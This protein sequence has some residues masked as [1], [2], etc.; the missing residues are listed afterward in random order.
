[1]IYLTEGNTPLNE[2]YNDEIVHLG[3]NTYQLTFRFPTSDPKW[4]LLKEETFLTADDLHGEQDFYIFEVEKQQGYIQVYANQVISLLN[5][6]IVS[7][8]EVDRVSGTRVLS[9]FA[10]SITRAN[11]FSFF[12]DIDDR[13]TLNIKDKN[14]MEV[15]AKGKHSILGQWGGDMVRNGYNLRLL[16]N[17]GSENE[18]LFM[19]KKNLS[20]YQHKTST[21]SLKTRI[22]FKTTVKGEGEN[23]V[24][25]DYMVVIDSPLLGNYSQIY[26]DVVE[27]NDQDVTD[28]ASLIEYGKQYFRTSMCDMLEDNLEISVVGQSDVAVQM[29]DVVSFYHEWYG[30]DVRKKITKYTYSPMAK[31]LKSIGFGTFQSSLANAI[32]GIVNDAVLNESRNLHQIF[33]ER[34]KKE[35]ANADRAFDAEFSKREKTIT[36]AIELAKAK[37]EEVKQEL[38]DTINQRF[39]SFDNGPLKEA[40]RKAEEALRNAGA[41]SSL[42]QES[43]RIGLDSVARLEAFKSQTTSAQTALSGDLDA[44]KRTIVNDIRPKQAQV[45]AEIAKQVEALVQTKKELSGASTLLAQEA[46]RIELDSVARLEAFKSQTTSAQTALSGDLDVLKRTIANDIRPKQAQAE[47]EIAKQVEALSRTK[48]ELSGASTLLAQEAKRIELDSVARLEAFKS[49]TTSAQTAL[50]GDLDVLKRTIANDIRPKQAQAETEIAKQV[51]ALSRTKNELAGVKSAQATY[52]ETTTRRLSELTNLA[53]GKASKSELTQ[54]AEELASRIASVQ[55]GSSR[56]YF[57][58]SRSRTFTTGGQAV[59]DYRTFIVPDFWKNSDRFKRDYVRISFDVTFPV[60]LVND[61]PAMVHF[62]AHPWYAYRNL[63][64]KGGTVERQHFEFTIDLSSSSEDYQTNN[65]FIRFG[66]N[67]GF[68][69]GLQVV[70]EN[71]MLSVGN[72]FP[73]YQPA[74]E[75]QEDRVSVVES[76]FKQRADSLDAGVSRLT[77]GLRTKADISSLNVTAE[78]IRQ[79]VKSLETDTQNKL[80]QKLSQ[81]EFE[82]R[83]GSIRQEILNATKDKASKSELT[84]TAEELASKI[85][86]V[87]LGRRNLLKGTKELARY[88]P[89]SEYNGFKVIRTVAG[90]TRYQDSY[91]ERT[92]IPTAGTEYIAI[93]YARASENDYPV[94]CHFYNPN[95]VVSSENSSGYKSRSS[96]GL[97]IIRLSTDWQ[98]CWVKWTQ[99]ATD[100]A[101]TVIIGRHGPQ[102]GGKEGVWVEICA[103][104]IFEGNLAGDWSPAYED[105]D[106]RV[107][108]VESNF[109]QRADSLEAGVSRL[110]EGLRTKADISSLNVTAENIRQSVKSLETDT[111]NKLNQKL[112]QAE[113]EVRAGSIRQEILNATKDKASKS[114]LTQTA[115]E[116]SSKIASVQ[117]G[118]RNYIRGTKRMMLA[119]GLWASGTFRPSGAGTAKTI[120]VSDSPVT[121][122]DKA[123]RLTSSN[124]RDQ[125]G[126]AQ[127]GFYISQGTYTMSCWVKGRRGQKVK[128]QTYWQVNDNSGISPIFTL[129]DENWTKLSFTSARNRAGV[130]SIGYVYL[131]NA[132]VGEYLDVLAPQLE[133]GSLATSSKEAPEDI[134]GQISTV[135]STFK[136][137]ANSLDAG[138]R[139]LTEGLRTKVD[140]SSLNV[141]A[142][143]IRQSVKRLETDT[144]NKLNQKLSQAEFEVRAGSIRQEILNATK[145][146]ASKSELTQTAEELSSKIASV[147]ASGRNL[148]LNSLFKQ[149]ISKTGIWTTSTYTAA[150]DSESKYLGHK[151]LKIIGLNPSGRDGGNP[152]VTYPALGQFGKV[153]PGS[154]TNQDVTISFYAKANKNGIMLRSRLGN[155]GYKTGNV[156]LSTEI[157]RYVVHI[158]KGWTNESKQTTNEWLFNFNQEGTVWIWMPKFEISDVDTS[159]SEAPEDI[160][161]QISTVESTFKQRANSLEAGVNRLTEGLRTKVDISALN[162]TAENIRQSVKSLETDTQNKLNQKLS[163]AEFEVRAGSIRQEILNA[164]KDKA[165]KSEL[166]QTAEE[167]SSKIASVQVGGINLLRNT[168]S[169]L[170]GDR[171]KGCWMSTS[172]GNGR[173]ISVEVLDPPKK[174]IKNMIRVI[175]NTNGGNKD[176]TQLVGLRIGEKYTI[177]CYARIASDSPNANVNL[178]F[179]SWANNTDLNRKFQKSISHKNWQKYSFTFTADAIENSIQFGQSGAGIIEICAPKIESGT[180]ATDY[181]EAPE[182]IEGQISTVESTFKQRANSLDA[183]V[184]RLTEGLRTKVDISA[185]NVTAENIRQSVKSLET[186]TQNKLNQKLSQAEF[187][188]RAG[189]IRQEILNATKDKADKT[190]VVSE[191]GKL[192]EEFS[193]MKVGGRNLWIKS[194]T[195]G[196]VIEKLPENH[197]TGQKECYRLENNSTLTFN[198]EPDFSSRLYQKVTFSA[199]IKYENVVQGR[200]FWNVFNC[201]KHYLFRKN[202]ETGVQSGPDYATLGMY[203]GSADWKYITFTYDYSEKTNFDQLKTS[204]RFNLEGATSGTAWVTGI[205]VEIGSVAT[206]WS[207]AP[208]DADGLITEAKATFERT[209]QGLR[210]DLSAIQEYVNKDGQRQEALRTYSREE[211]ARQATA[212]RELVNRDFVGKA[213]YQEDVK[214]IN[215]RIE[216]VKT[217]ANKD[218]ASQI[219]SYRQSVDGKFT[220]ISSQIT[221]YKQ[222]VGGQ[223]SGLSNRLTSSEQGTT[224]QISN[225]SNRINSN[226]QGTDNQIS[227]LKTQVATNKDNAERQMGRISDQVSANKANA[228]SQFANVTNQ[229]AR[230]VETTDFQRVKETSKLYERILGN[231]E[232]GIADKVARMALTNQLFQVEVAKN[233]SNGQNLLK[234]T[235][236]FS[237]GW[238][239]KGANW[240]KHAEKYKGVDVLFKNNSWNGVGQ[241]IDAKIGEVYT[242]SLWMKSDWKNDTVNFYVNRNGSVEKGWG[243]PSE[244]SVAITSEWKRYSFTFKITVDGFIFPRVERLNQN[245]NLY[246]AGLK[247]EK[248]SYATPY[249]EAPE[250]TDEAIRSVQSQLTGSWAVQNINSAGDIISGI[251]LGAN[252]HNRFVGKLTHITGETL[253]DRAVIKSAMVD[254]LKTGNFEAGSVTTTILDA[255]AV[256]AEKLKVDNALI[257]KLTANDAFIDQL[258]SK[259]IFSIKVESVI[260]SSTF[261][262]AYQGRIGGFTLGQFDQGGGRWISG[263]NQ[264]SVGMGNGA[265]HGVR[266]AF[267]ANWGNNWNYA[268]PKAWNVNTDGKMYCRNEVGF[269]DQVDFSNS[270]RANFYGNTTFSR[271]P[272]FSNGIELGSKDVLGDGWNPKGGR[273]AVVWWNQVGSGSVKYWMEQKSDRRLKENITDTAVKALDKINRLRMVAFDFI[274][275]KKHEEIGLIAQEAETIVPRIVS[276]DPEN[277]D[278]YLH[279]DYTALVP[280]LIKA[281]QELNQKIEK[282]EK[283]IA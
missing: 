45:E 180:L 262:E 51:E 214:G 248:G 196:A 264:F 20:S 178:L 170:I 172:G 40:K 14:A 275:N 212:V 157:K 186:D 184:S 103:P 71:A 56:N 129:K 224:T 252:G 167:L 90:A 53:N 198:L 230:K 181:S 282:M 69:A 250:D 188:V 5:N 130:A 215:Q 31:L 105:Q 280:Y 274:E 222:D 145:D 271:S 114:E 234:G 239:N 278:G 238:K 66:T 33:E 4:E 39:N 77:E 187:E 232:N 253:I 43:K 22:T 191:A 246:I 155:I 161:G 267:W 125:I 272:V 158:P 104:A 202:S 46:K 148:F 86:S 189:S 220:D 242:F 249:T 8:I 138:V 134:E 205:K 84:Q 279:I 98:L 17:G 183:G 127:D 76:N 151:A 233:A 18:S 29:F 6:Y 78:N 52:E 163:Q 217:S 57:R 270:S 194:K 61:M 11:P 171:S 226:K 199:W 229:L 115:E 211:S 283:T 147:Q 218:I 136:Q 179:R 70:I 173:A 227:N 268:G 3:N 228:D 100:Q 9:A 47:A 109:K 137:R 34:L 124:A 93:F 225:L 44:L 116:L 111:Q 95:T 87:H 82:V 13:H 74:Y 156:T 28:E 152:K 277:P 118:G 81:A 254:K 96:D 75:D 141:T 182:D 140:I 19:Y 165:S 206:D 106:E 245:T 26:E 219:A 162:V 80:N 149:D 1:M 58:N 210:T 235:K 85:A 73:A 121:G 60:A 193:K 30:L 132:E 113:F 135:E 150:I 195:V 27:V 67:Y 200:N 281:I 146:K 273:N 32:G 102:V 153:I 263:V 2:A 203:K 176:L 175:E 15:L 159:Y 101:K 42:A 133:D 126:I 144:Q 185:L 256:T 7:S 177:S 143:N 247:L 12:S 190:L 197:V 216:A 223:I 54:T 59:Y 221:T 24:D 255:E 236:D 192:R 164:T 160:E 169:L 38:S 120:D 89:V 21:K 208:E 41:S 110:T 243:V 112:S 63:I 72:Y 174:M 265:G 142:E 231:T 25:H 168:A 240:K 139:S 207:P 209:A 244:T 50:S 68:P 261:L 35:I 258:I 23:A 119:R 16:K 49:Q 266:T 269:Y 166:T 237:G 65:V 122:F 99:T 259:R 107:S 62:S 154:T 108:A 213:T 83:A 128:L 97:S 37:A 251:N 257:R 10:G 123:I 92:V 91:V 64:F 36:D 276:R 241:E 117:V 131:V 79:S 48:N 204:L 55:A 201:F 94:R 260:S 88:K